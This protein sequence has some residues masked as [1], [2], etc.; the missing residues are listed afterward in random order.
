[1]PGALRELS[2]SRRDWCRGDMRHHVAAVYAFARAAD[3]FADEGQR[4]VEERH[5]LLDGWL[6]RL[7]RTPS[8]SRIAGPVAVELR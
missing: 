4:P 3:D 5:R 1:M 7:Q 2:R 6:C 8:P